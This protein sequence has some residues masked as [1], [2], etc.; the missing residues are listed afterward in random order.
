MLILWKHIFFLEFQK[1]QA[2]NNATIPLVCL[3]CKYNV[4]VCTIK[5]YVKI[6]YII[7][8]L[9][10]YTNIYMYVIKHRIEQFL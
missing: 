2:H 10:F 9:N 1:H 4:H 8:L 6:I 5:H 3:L 7:I